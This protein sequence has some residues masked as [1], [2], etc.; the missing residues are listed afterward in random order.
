VPAAFAALAVPPARGQ[1][2]DS[3]ARAQ[4]ADA[5][6]L[7]LPDST[8]PRA[9]PF[10]PGGYDDK[11]YLEGI[12]G[13]I[14]VGG[15]VEANGQWEREDGAT[16]ELGVELTR[17]N[18]LAATDIRRRVRIFSEVEFEEGGK[19]ITLELAQID[20]YLHRAAN[21]RAGVLLL[22]LGRF[23]LAHDAP[24]NELPRRPAV[25]A[26]LIGVALSQPGLGLFGQLGPRAGSRFTYELYGV[27]GYHDGL[28]NDSPE[29][30]RLPAGR[31]NSE[32][33]NASPA[34]V[35]RLEWSSSLRA[36]VGI[37]GYH[38]AYNAYRSEGLAVETRRHVAVGVLD[39]QI[40]LRG[41]SLSA[42]GALIRVEVPPDLGGIFATRQ[43]GFYVQASRPFWRGA[44]QSMPDSWFTG[45]LRADVVDF[46]RDVAGDSF[47]SV[48]AGI[49]FRPVPET[50]LKVAFMRGEGRDRFN[51][52]STAA[53][54]E[55][56]IATY[57]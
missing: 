37:S 13:R 52:L 9:R 29:G 33:E 21:L 42:E 47:R 35:G 45:A 11:P 7:G 12:F 50:A 36:A 10:V 26:E 17:W 46:D 38:G 25:A 1:P 49:N 48:T 55:L 27:T 31:A 19:E 4:P 56:G 16:T 2:A 34:W 40:P 43:A 39:A 3:T 28:L 32:D 23:N 41:F 30:T 18:L 22:P 57:F 6:P 5:T 51:N 54:L 14:A 20:L 24:R 8:A 53:R 15:Y 44:F